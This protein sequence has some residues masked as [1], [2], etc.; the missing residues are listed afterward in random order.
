MIIKKKFGKNSSTF[1]V[2]GEDFHEVVMNSSKLSFGDLDKCGVCSNDNLV[3]GAHVTKDDGY[4]FTYVK[5]LACKS[6][7]NFGQQKK[8]TSINYYRMKE[9]AKGDRILVDGKPQLDW[10][11]PEPKEV[12]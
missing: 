9:D 4:K 7:L 6:T 10:R 5:C 3:L 1:V 11:K 2:S 12:K 8:D